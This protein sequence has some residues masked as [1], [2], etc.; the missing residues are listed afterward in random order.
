MR[1]SL[2]FLSDLPLY[3]EEK[4]YTIH[5]TA[6]EGLKNSNCEFTV[7]D[8]IEVEDVRG[9]EN[10]GNFLERGFQFK[11]HASKVPVSSSD[12]QSPGPQNEL[13]QLYLEETIELAKAETEATKVILFDWRVSFVPGPARVVLMTVCQ[14]RSSASRPDAASEIPDSDRSQFL[15]PASIAHS[16]GTNPSW[17]IF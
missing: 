10:S 12:F 2:S 16:G 15:A 14:V 5:G 7:F 6:A 11:H 9:E 1:V 17:Q 8:D 3:K 4:P 13:V